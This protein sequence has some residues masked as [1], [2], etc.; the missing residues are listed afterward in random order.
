MEFLILFNFNAF[1]RKFPQPRVG[2]VLDGAAWELG[3]RGVDATPPSPR[4]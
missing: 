4:G 1:E 2:S 3:W